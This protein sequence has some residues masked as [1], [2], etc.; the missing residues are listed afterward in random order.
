MAMT[1]RLDRGRDT[2]CCHLPAVPAAVTQVD[3]S[4][5]AAC[6]LQ[7]TDT[8][9]VRVLCYRWRGQS[10]Y[11]PSTLCVG[12]KLTPR[13]DMD[14]TRHR[15]LS[16][17]LS[18][19]ASSRA[20]AAHL[21]V[22]GDCSGQRHRRELGRKAQ[23]SRVVRSSSFSALSFSPSPVPPV[24]ELHPLQL[25]TAAQ[26]AVHFHLHTHSPAVLG[27]TSSLRRL[28]GDRLTPT[29]GCDQCDSTATHY[30]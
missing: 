9:S 20:M 29:H 28:C 19:T 2:R 4:H 21:C 1:W 10:D 12:S 23:S 7:S 27:S 6:L 16:H 30:C 25:H 8:G 3:V 11:T 15:Q 22:L 13:Q 26:H 24:P 18:L 17:T 5:S 14:D